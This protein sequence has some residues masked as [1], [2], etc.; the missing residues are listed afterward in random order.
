MTIFLAIIFISVILL[1]HEL[2][3]FWLAKISGVKVEEFGFGFPPRIWAKKIGETEYSFNWL[4]LGGFN[5]INEESFNRQPANRRALILAGGIIANVFLGWL[6]FSLV[7]MIGSKPLVIVS[8][9]APNSPAA[10][11]GIQK[12]DAIISVN[13]SKETLATPFSGQMFIEFVN[14]YRGEILTLKI[15]R[16]GET[17]NFQAMSRKTPPEGE[18]SLGIAIVDAGIPAKPFG[19]SLIEAFKTTGQVIGLSFLG[20]YRLATQAFTKPA[21][22]DALTGPI[23]VVA[24]AGQIGKISFAYFLQI[25]A[26]ISLGFAVF[27]AL[28]FPALDGGHLLFILIE[29]IKG[30]P[31]P[32]K[33]KGL[34][35]GISFGLLLILMIFVTIKDIKGLL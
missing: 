32:A 33:I 35:N 15:S 24:L 10:L 12:N 6:F 26:F 11:A 23:G 22:L 13:S 31:I 25:M 28:P 3:H 34:I 20:I 30:S 18:G 2:G 8:D 5:K 4:P 21:V 29:K 9:L 17:I 16:A 14:R 27:N 19:Q 7:F 1:L